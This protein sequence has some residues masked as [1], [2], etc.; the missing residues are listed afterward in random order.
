MQLRSARPWLVAIFLVLVGAHFVF[1]L[2]RVCA[3][4]ELVT[5]EWLSLFI[6]IT[7]L[8]LA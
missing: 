3:W 4:N 6:S 5:Y 2:F 8:Q 1:Y 7:C